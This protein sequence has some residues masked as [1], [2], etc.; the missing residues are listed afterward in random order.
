MNKQKGF[1][2]I[3]VIIVFVLALGLAGWYF[4][5]NKNKPLNTV[6]INPP[7]ASVDTNTGATS[8]TPQQP[9]QTTHTNNNASNTPDTTIVSAPP[10]Y[11]VYADIRAGFSSRLSINGFAGEISDLQYSTHYKG[12]TPQLVH[13]Y[14]AFTTSNIKAW[15][16]VWQEE[17]SDTCLKDLS[18]SSSIQ[19]RK[20]NNDLTVSQRNWGD[21]AMGQY[22]D[23]RIYAI[24]NGKKKY[25]V[26]GQTHGTRPNNLEG[27]AYDDQEKLNTA[28]LAD[29]DKA[30]KIFVDN[31]KIL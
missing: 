7:T 18:T 24:S 10:E 9:S 23:L 30:T 21:A 8:T 1:S 3:V 4:L 22:E 6:Y 15:I 31:F 14:N 5:T 28:A 2:Q 13:V 26:V 19:P 17:N 12:V 27:T 29:F 20:N 25:C 16:V 11:R